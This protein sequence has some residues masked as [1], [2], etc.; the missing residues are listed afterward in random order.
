MIT[1]E[2]GAYTGG[3]IGK[4]HKSGRM[5]SGVY[6]KCSAVCENE[7]SESFNRVLHKLDKTGNNAHIGI[8]GCMLKQKFQQQNVTPVKIDVHWT[9]D[10]QVQHYPF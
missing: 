8:R 10:S 6:E 5:V 7:I 4:F 3:D 2:V 1:W 9:S